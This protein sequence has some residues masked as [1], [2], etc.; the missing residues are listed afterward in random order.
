MSWFVFSQNYA[1]LV[2]EQVYR[3]E[4]QYMSVGVPRVQRFE[5]IISLN[6]HYFD[7][8]VAA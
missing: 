8:P 1:S 7:P 4:I 3:T 6:S 2:P 5:P